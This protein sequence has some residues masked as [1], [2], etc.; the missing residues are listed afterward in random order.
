MEQTSNTYRP[1]S[2]AAYIIST[3]LYL[4]FLAR[5]FLFGMPSKDYYDFENFLMKNAYISN[6]NEIMAFT[7]FFAV[8]WFAILFFT[9]KNDSRSNKLFVKEEA[10]FTGVFLFIMMLLLVIVSYS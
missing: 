9:K 4:L 5:V 8:A 7:L 10:F 3:T 1:L 6:L 2:L